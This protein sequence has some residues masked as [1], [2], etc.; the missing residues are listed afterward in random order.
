MTMKI[1]AYGWPLGGMP[2]ATTPAGDL[3]GMKGWK[4]TADG[5]KYDPREGFGV[6]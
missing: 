4:G 5:R 2:P 3:G 1:C 6:R